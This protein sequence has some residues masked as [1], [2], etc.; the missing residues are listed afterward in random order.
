MVSGGA[1]IVQLIFQHRLQE[2]KLG[3]GDGGV[4]E[5]LAEKPLG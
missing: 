2:M 4:V 1:V 5:V 3:E